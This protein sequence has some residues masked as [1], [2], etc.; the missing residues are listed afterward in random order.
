MLGAPIWTKVHTLRREAGCSPL[1]I[2]VTSRL[3]HI[4]SSEGRLRPDD[5]LCLPPHSDTH[6]ASR[7]HTKGSTSTPIKWQHTSGEQEQHRWPYKY[8]LT[9]HHRNIIPS[10]INI[11]AAIQTAAVDIQTTGAKLRFVWIPGHA[12]IRGN[13]R[14][15]QRSAID[16]NP[17]RRYASSQAQDA[18]RRELLQ[19][20]KSTKW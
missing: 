4:Y 14:A 19:G 3:C 13:E 8:N 7:G 5:S 16:N 1:T 11:T 9:C 12:S 18:H 2:R 15:L 17:L 20:S 10:H 6:G